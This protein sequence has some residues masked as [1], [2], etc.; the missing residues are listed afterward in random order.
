MPGLSSEGFTYRM[1]HVAALTAWTLCLGCLK[2]LI[3]RWTPISSIIMSTGR[4]IDPPGWPSNAR[5]SARSLTAHTSF[6]NTLDSS[7]PCWVSNSLL[8]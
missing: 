1:A 3:F 5:R 4:G 8:P 6:V 2:S 7:A